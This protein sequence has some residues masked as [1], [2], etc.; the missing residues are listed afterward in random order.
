[1]A[2]TQRS[3]F[4]SSALERHIHGQE[5]DVL[6]RIICPPVFLFLWLLL[7]L[8]V[9]AGLF[10]WSG[11]VPVDVAGEGVV[12]NT[13]ATE[14]R[15]GSSG[16]SV[17]VI[18]IPTQ[19][20]QGSTPTDVFAKVRVNQ[21]VHLVVGSTDV[22]ITRKVEAVEPTII[23]PAAARKQYGL[24]GDLALLVTQPSVVVKVKLG[25]DFVATAYAGSSVRAAVD[26]GARRVISFVP[27]LDSLIG[28]N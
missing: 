2:D 22:Q 23:S 21:T 10:A 9:I 1:M 14:A 13:A 26:V 11:R 17:A 12:V 19:S 27:G 3:I 16:E 7:S 24:S 4:R 5:K 18:F 20:P 25:S 8:S 6:P 28:E 15:Q